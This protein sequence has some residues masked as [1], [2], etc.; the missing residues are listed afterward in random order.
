MTDKVVFFFELHQ[1]IR[2]KRLHLYSPPNMPKSIDEVFDEEANNSILDRVVS[3]AYLPA[4]RILYESLSEVKGFRVTMSISGV[5]LEQLLDRH[6]ELV[7]LIRDMVS[8]EMVDLAAQ[9][10]YHSLAWLVDRGEF[11]EQVAE[12]AK[13]VQEL[14]GVRP[15][16]AENTEFMYNN[17]VGCELSAMGFKVV[18]TEGAERA[19]GW[20]SPNYVYRNP[21]CGVKVLTRNYMLSDDIGFRFSNRSWVGFP[22]TADK[23]ARWVRD[24]PGD[25]VVVALD[26][27]TFGEHHWPE[28]GIHEFLRWL[29]RELSRA[30]V[31]MISAADAA[32]MEPKGDLDVP[33]WNTISWADER[34]LSAW[35]GNDMQRE[36][37]GQ[38]RRSYYFAKA[39]GG[40]TLRLWRLLSTSDHFYYMATKT[41]PSGE[42]HS[43]FS[44]LGTPQQAYM[45]YSIA[46]YLLNREI[47][48]LTEKDKCKLLLIR[49]P[50]ELCYHAPSGSACTLRDALEL[51]ASDSRLLESMDRWSRDVFSVRMED[52]VDLVAKCQHQ[53][54]PEPYAQHRRG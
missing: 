24:S 46:I 19:L 31:R 25:L 20:R 3:K 10:Y 53:N 35:A 37:I 39:L 15:T 9:T 42:V 49:L 18:M 1:P 6:R 5:L 32:E 14:F 48:S 16:V 44:H 38:L 47:R 52:V 43:Y 2:L 12:Q 8:K 29:P 36:A 26:Y 28:T 17:D 34:D 23:Y 50:E 22:L 4:T 41:G 54:R 11:R 13:L 21:L 27:E 7:E 40:R 45:T 30:G 33:P 51:L